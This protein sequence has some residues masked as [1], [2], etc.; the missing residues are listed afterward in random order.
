[1]LLMLAQSSC[2]VPQTDSSSTRQDGIRWQAGEQSVHGR[3]LH[4]QLSNA[5]YNHHH[6]RSH[7]RHLLLCLRWCQSRQLGPP[8]W[9]LWA[10]SFS[11]SNGGK[12]TFRLHKYTL[13]IWTEAVHLWMLS[14]CLH[15][16]VV[17]K[18]DNSIAFA[19]LHTAFV[20]A[21]KMQI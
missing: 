16:V 14:Q 12:V 20:S 15:T 8:W 4:W 19:Y 7:I 10:S 5:I 21:D 17:T 2:S 1:M 13:A 11:F 3:M 9:L 6:H 18:R